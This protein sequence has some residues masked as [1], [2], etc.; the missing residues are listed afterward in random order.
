MKSTD[1][2]INLLIASYYKFG[3]DD[4]CTLLKI[5]N[6]K[7]N[8][9]EDIYYDL[10]K[11]LKHY[12]QID[13]NEDDI[14]YIEKILLKNQDLVQDLVQ[15]NQE[16]LKFYQELVNQLSIDK[17][18]EYD[19]EYFENMEF[20][21]EMLSIK[22]E[23]ESVND[24]KKLLFINDKLLVP[25]DDT[26]CQVFLDNKM[27]SIEFYR[28]RINNNKTMS[29]STIDSENNKKFF[30]I[31]KNEHGYNASY[32]SHNEKI[33][34]SYSFFIATGL[35]KIDFMLLNYKDDRINYQLS[36]DMF[37][38][39]DIDVNPLD[40][41]YKAL[42][43]SFFTKDVFQ[44]LKDDI[45]DTEL[46]ELINTCFSN[47]S[48]CTS[49]IFMDAVRYLNESGLVV[50]NEKNL[51][52]KLLD[53]EYD[54]IDDCFSD[55][56]DLFLIYLKKFYEDLSKI[57]DINLRSFYETL[58]KDN[59]ALDKIKKECGDIDNMVEY[60]IPKL[61]VNVFNNIYK[62]DT[63]Q[64]W[65]NMFQIE[66]FTEIVNNRDFSY[67]MNK[68]D[69]RVTLLMPKVT[70]YQHFNGGGW[71]EFC[72][73]FSDETDNGNR[74]SQISFNYPRTGF[75][76]FRTVDDIINN[77]FLTTYIANDYEK[78]EYFQMIFAYREDKPVRFILSYKDDDM[79]VEC[80]AANEVLV[81]SPKCI[82]KYL[83]NNYKP[84]P[85]LKD[86]DL[87]DEIVREYIS[88]DLPVYQLI[89]EFL[90][91]LNYNPVKK[92]VA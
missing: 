76:C 47:Y 37:N 18:A 33:N 2:F 63:L 72:H 8:K 57:D 60:F 74:L 10:C 1:W 92:L 6:G 27:V 45:G 83:N 31:E 89:S 4:R 70:D 13:K 77:S 53:G 23:Y 5:I 75:T 29:F 42:L 32:I 54:S 82:V 81:G 73:L 22:F 41:Q 24:N 85:N 28:N 34:C 66:L 20:F 14:F 25:V 86:I 40:S 84:A 21:L 80:N 71:S 48:C 16:F 91:S 58:I 35:E 15:N 88:S 87:V 36:N 26:T 38:N 55:F 12:K 52:D 69:N 65:L 7:L 46:Y 19:E 64:K 30:V 51:L 62:V 44:V 59:S 11:Y 78:K 79:I 49:N 39:G 43:N 50:E 90:P 56:K 3:A 9:I 67:V 68:K 17:V 61:S